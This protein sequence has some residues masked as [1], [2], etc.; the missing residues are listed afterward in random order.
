MEIF[1]YILA[2]ASV[3]FAVGLTGVGGGSLMTPLLL[4]FGFPPH[5]AVGTDLLYAAI[6]KAGGVF[7]HQKHRTISWPVVG[8]LAL[9]SIPASLLTIL[10]LGVF[11][12]GAQGYQSLITSSLGVMLIST[13]LVLI[14]KSQLVAWVGR[15]TEPQSKQN[16]QRNVWPITC[17]MGAVMGALVTLSSVGAGAFCTAVLLVL[18]P[19]L[20][21]IRVVGTDLAHAVPLTLIGGLGHML[22]G[23]VDYT[24]L[25]ALLMGSLP[26]IHFGTRFAKKMPEQWLRPILASALMGLGIK[27]AIF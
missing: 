17:L 8:A 6:T 11:F 18:Y 12:E 24:L 22:L 15:Q 14:F 4:L 1:Y 9:G 23:N 5:I 26:A 20:K 19:E 13:S 27:Y 16:Q 7:S 2:G 21:A 25:G 10:I 3:G